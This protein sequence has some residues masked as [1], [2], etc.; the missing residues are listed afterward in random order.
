LSNYL[1]D[2]DLG[3]FNI[4]SSNF[5]NTPI[6]IGTNPL[7]VDSNNNGSSY[8]S[9]IFFN[10]FEINATEVT[11][12][13]FEFNPAWGLGVW[14][15]VWLVPKGLKRNLKRINLF[16]ITK[17]LPVELVHLKLQQC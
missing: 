13:P 6:G 12:I 15:G 17:S 3:S 4:W 9:Q 1:I 16:K 14:G 11:P 10:T 5:S 8:L 7:I 2:S